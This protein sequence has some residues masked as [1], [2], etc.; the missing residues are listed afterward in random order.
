MADKANQRDDREVAD[1]DGRFRRPDSAFRDWIS[2]ENGAPFPPEKGRYVLYLN[3]G[4]PWAH[5]TNIVRSLKGLEDIIQLVVMDHRMGPDGW[6]YNP[7]RKGT[8]PKDPLHGF[9][10]HKDLYMKADP[11][12]TG[13]YTVPTLWDKKNETIVN[14]ESSELIRMFYSE[15]DSLLPEKLREGN[16]PDGGLLPSHLKDEIEKMNKWVYDGLN[17]GVYKTGFAQAQ[18]AYEENVKIV[19]ESLDRVED[20]LAKSEGPFL[21]GKHLTEA[22]IRL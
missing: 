12:Y 17:N 10:K 6:A 2:S 16:K 18:D 21:F 20:V 5:R 3:K 7:E 1:K 11:N 13:R 22:D 14:N 19:F 9:T 15:F 4:C 8:D